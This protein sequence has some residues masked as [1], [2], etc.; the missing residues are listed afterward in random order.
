MIVPASGLGSGGCSTPC[1]ITEVITWTQGRDLPAPR[2]LNAL[3]HHG[4]HHIRSAQSRGRT[5]QV[6]NALRHHG[7]HHDTR[8]GARNPDRA[9]LNALR[10]HGGHHRPSCLGKAVGTVVCSTP[11]GIT[12][13]VTKFSTITT[14]P[15]KSAQRLAASRRSS[16]ASSLTSRP[17]SACAQR[18]AASRR[19]SRTGRGVF[20]RGASECS[21]P[22]G[23]TEVITR[24]QGNA[25]R[26][27]LL[28]LNALRHHG[29]HHGRRDRLRLHPS[30]VLNALR[31][32]GGHH[33]E[34]M[35]LWKWCIRCSTPCGITEVITVII[36]N[37]VANAVQC[38]TPCGITEVITQ[39]DRDDG[40]AAGVLNAL[41]HHGG[42]HPPARTG[43]VPR[44]QCSTPCGITEVIT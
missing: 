40:R 42:H 20:L 22:C 15:T 23:I 41:R 39:S 36:E 18:L 30:V 6:L 12:E 16:H 1:G 43:A 38:S 44:A 33:I 8:R 10:H 32:H 28:V 13:V 14:S 27:G 25:R 17:G 3:R 4:G 34:R 21:T 2:V 7:G 37:F 11:C 24:D 35:Q 26:R 19:S 5:N 9:V 31:H 29:G